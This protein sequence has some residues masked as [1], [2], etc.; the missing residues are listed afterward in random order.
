[1]QVP[2]QIESVKKYDNRK[3]LY[4]LF[5]SYFSRYATGGIFITKKYQ[6]LS[7]YF[8]DEP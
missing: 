5:D 8:L 6:L 4:I 2:K 3:F 1:M 7:W